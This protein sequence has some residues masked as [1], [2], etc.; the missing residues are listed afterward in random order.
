MAQQPSIDGRRW[1]ETDGSPFLLSPV[2]LLPSWTGY[3]GDYDLVIEMT[4]SGHS[5]PYAVPERNVVVLGDEPL[6]AT[7][8]ESRSLIVQWIHGDS[9]DEMR[10]HASEVDLD[11]IA[12]HQGP[13]LQSDGELALVD[14]ATP[15]DEVADEDMFVFTSGSGRFRLDSAEVP[16]APHCAA[17]LHRLVALTD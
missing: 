16:L 9:E 13:V 1:L 2:A 4:D 14:A 8:I 3:N 12:W 17:K 6:P 15:G 7:I 5:E 11:A 10:K